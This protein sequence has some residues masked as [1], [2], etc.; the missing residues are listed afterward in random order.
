LLILVLN[1]SLEFALLEVANQDL[2]L[3]SVVHLAELP[4]LVLLEDSERTQVRRPLLLQILHL[5]VEL[6]LSGDVVV[7]L[8]SLVITLPLANGYKPTHP[9]PIPIP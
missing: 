9:S 3:L 1:K 2:L 4:Q 5:F 8:A 7:E 6:S